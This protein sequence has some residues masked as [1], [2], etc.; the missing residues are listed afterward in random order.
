[1]A[2]TQCTPVRIE[3]EQGEEEDSEMGSERQKEREA[4]SAT[5]VVGQRGSPGSCLGEEVGDEIAQDE[6][7]GIPAVQAEEMSETAV[8]DAGNEEEGAQEIELDDGDGIVDPPQCEDTA[9][10]PQEGGESPPQST[11]WKQS[12]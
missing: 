3:P 8:E 5:S 2:Q 7:M 9:K 11:V 6:E 12:R 1:M 4:T 10:D